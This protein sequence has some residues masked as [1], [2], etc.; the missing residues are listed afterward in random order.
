MTEQTPG[1]AE[2]K[3]TGRPEM[4]EATSV[5]AVNWICAPGLAKVIVCDDL[6]VTALLGAESGPGPPH[7]RLAR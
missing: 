2:V 7:L 1:V 4:V 5:G 3:T 6:G